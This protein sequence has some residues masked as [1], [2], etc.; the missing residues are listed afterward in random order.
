MELASSTQCVT[1]HDIISRAPISDV[2]VRNELL[3]R[4][5][6]RPFVNRMPTLF[7]L[8][9]IG[10]AAVNIPHRLTL[11]ALIGIFIA[12]N[13]VAAYTA[14][15]V[16]TAIE[17]GRN[18]NAE[19]YIWLTV[20]FLC[21]AVWGLM[22]WP[23]TD[24]AISGPERPIITAVIMV[25]VSAGCLVSSNA[26]GLPR[27]I[28]AG[29][30]ITAV[31]SS[32]IF[33]DMEGALLTSGAFLMF[34]AMLN[35]ASIMRSEAV[36]N[37][38]TELEKDE[39]TAELAAA[40]DRAQYLSRHDSLTGLLN[41]RDFDRA[42]TSLNIDR[43]AQSGAIIIFD[44]DHFKSINDRFGHMDGDKALIAAADLTRMVLSNNDLT[45]S[46][47]YAAARWGGE[48]FVVALAAKNEMQAA[49]I[50][51][52]IRT[53]FEDYSETGWPAELHITASFGVAAWPARSSLQDA[54]AAADARLLQAK[55]AGR[56]RVVA[57]QT[58]A[59]YPPVRARA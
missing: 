49:E 44:L 5:I 53:A 37:L 50:A 52:Q 57:A 42:A 23:V 56:N 20:E 48:E 10:I 16:K 9:V 30:I 40:L 7:S 14:G 26:S 51:E 18:I 28:I 1:D 55:S 29:F 27:S 45:A 54:I 41:R 3:R 36:R 46:E 43:S 25:T 19:R 59:I 33:Y 24:P 6:G 11:W 15:R 39:L 8:L 12:V 17:K 21:G 34:V 35:I 22:L 58:E 47:D 38:K 13:F 32:I 31:P 2:A 4:A